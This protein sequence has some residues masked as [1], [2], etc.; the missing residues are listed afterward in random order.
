MSIFI[1]H[2]LHE[3]SMGKGYP[4]TTAKR[5]GRKR[6]AKAGDAAAAAE[7]Q[8]T[9]PVCGSVLDGESTASDPERDEAHRSSSDTS[10][11]SR[12]YA[13]GVLLKVIPRPRGM[14]MR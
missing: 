9:C 8:V 2:K 11:N 3:L 13:D 12:S 10:E 4:G 1:A 14:K 7:P 6:S 5:R